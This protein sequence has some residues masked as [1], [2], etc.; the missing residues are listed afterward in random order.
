MTLKKSKLIIIT[1]TPGTGKTTVANILCKKLGYFRI[2]WHDLLKEDK[3]L[4]LGYDRNRKCYDIDVKLLSKKIE[5]ILKDKANAGKVFVFDTHMSHLL[6]KKLMGLAIVM[7]CSNLKKLRERLEERKYG[8]KKIE[9][10]LECE[11]FDECLDSVFELGV[12]HIVI[13]SSK[14]IVQKDLVKEIKDLMK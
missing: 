4:S 9:E 14:R 11:I 6:P 1:G 13:D 3:N 2:D 5:T 12:K 10:N 7:K 8:K